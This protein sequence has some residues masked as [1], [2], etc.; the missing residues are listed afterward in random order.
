[1]KYIES[2]DKISLKVNEAFELLNNEIIKANINKEKW[3][4][5]SSNKFVQVYSERKSISAKKRDDCYYI[6]YKFCLLPFDIKN[7]KLIS[8]ISFK[9][10]KILCNK[11]FF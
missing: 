11:N 6:L 2:S 1:M 9:I 3:L 8:A 4:V 10:K 5:K 7:I